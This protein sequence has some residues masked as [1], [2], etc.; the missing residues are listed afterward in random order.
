MYT[1]GK[2]MALLANSKEQKA[3]IGVYLPYIKYSLNPCN[4]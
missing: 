1:E 2:M 3:L 4:M